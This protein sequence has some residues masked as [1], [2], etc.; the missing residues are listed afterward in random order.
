ML[1]V[2][3]NGRLTVENNVLNFG[4]VSVFASMYEYVTGEKQQFKGSFYTAEFSKLFV[5]IKHYVKNL[6]KNEEELEYLMW[7]SQIE[8]KS[9]E[10]RSVTVRDYQTQKNV[11]EESIRRQDAN[12]FE[13]VESVFWL[14]GLKNINP[15]LLVRYYSGD[16]F[17]YY[18]FELFKQAQDR[19]FLTYS[20]ANEM[21]RF[22][23]KLFRYPYLSKGMLNQKTLDKPVKL[24][25]SEDPYFSADYFY[26]T[27]QYDR[28]LDMVQLIK[29]KDDELS[30]K[31]ILARYFTKDI[32]KDEL[33][34]WL[35]LSKIPEGEFLYYFLKGNSRS[36]PEKNPYRIVVDAV[37]NISSE[38]S[39][40]NNIGEEVFYTQVLRILGFYPSDEKL[41]KIANLRFGI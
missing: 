32:G 41:I 16:D 4:I 26:F 13:K 30:L 17:I 15:V 31:V 39:I 37:E 28:F 14:L 1:L 24:L 3:K 20:F 6:F 7:A 36:V 27:Q 40:I 5:K 38:D 19:G 34:G 18:I 23:R 9:I 8:E 25:Y 11:F 33:V 22:L 21:K 12:T 29:D 10:N 2:Q 35:S